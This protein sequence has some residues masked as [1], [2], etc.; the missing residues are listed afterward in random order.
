MSVLDTVRAFADCRGL[1]RRQVV[2]K[3]GQ[4]VREADDAACQMVAMATEIDEQK[5]ART[6][7]E[8]DFDRAAIA[9]SGLLEDLRVEREKTK[10]LEAELAPYRAAEA[11][12]N[13]VTVPPMERDTRNGADQATGP[14][15]VRPLWAAADA[16]LLGPV[17]RVSTSGASADPSQPPRAASWGV[18]D[19][20][21]LSTMKGAAS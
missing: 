12:A 8:E 19:T 18:D 17:V 6:K 10:Q 13:R 5:A 20:Q 21:P 11:N 15:D 9:Y 4:L 7:A 16:G 3:V 2:Q 14:I 1:T